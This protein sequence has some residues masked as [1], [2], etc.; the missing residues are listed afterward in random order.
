M[1]EY[2]VVVVGGGIAGSALASVL[3]PR[4][5]RVLVLERQTAYRDKVR[6]EFMVPWGVA[7]AVELGLDE[8][9]LAAGGV[10]SPSIASYGDWID[11]AEA[12]AAALPL[13]MLIPGV[14][15]A[16]CVGHPQASEALN[17]RAT[18]QGAD[19]LRGIGDVEVT[20][21]PQPSVRYEFQR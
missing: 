8:T 11:P 19:V 3:A 4:G 15:G 9:L 16:M 13:A 10:Y 6:G 20:A 21:G 18:E 14:D 17:T 12:K 5:L 1:D 2:D 7:E